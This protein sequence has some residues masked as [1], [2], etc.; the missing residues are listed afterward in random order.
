[1]AKN[2]L[3]ESRTRR[4]LKQQMNRQQKIELN[5][6]EKNPSRDTPQFGQTNEKGLK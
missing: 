2:L 1:M 3:T 5:G 6:L 4:L